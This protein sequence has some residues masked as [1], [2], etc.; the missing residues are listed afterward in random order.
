MA[1]NW[2]RAKTISGKDAG[3]GFLCPVCRLSH[4]H[5]APARV[6]HCGRWE[7]APFFTVKLPTRQIKTNLVFAESPI[8]EYDVKYVVSKTF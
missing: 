2:F 1:S 8:S 7:D 3:L 4:T 5:S 6:F